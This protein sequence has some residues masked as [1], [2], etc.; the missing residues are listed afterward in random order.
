MH[1]ASLFKKKVK[2][3][4]EVPE[5]CESDCHSESEHEEVEQTF[6]VGDL[7]LVRNTPP[8]EDYRNRPELRKLRKT[9][10]WAL[11]T[12]VGFE[13]EPAEYLPIGYQGGG[14]PIVTLTKS[15]RGDWEKFDEIRLAPEPETVDQKARRM[16][17]AGLKAETRRKKEVHSEPSGVVAPYTEGS[18]IPAK[19]KPVSKGNRVGDVISR[20]MRK[21]STTSSSSSSASASFSSAGSMSRVSSVYSTTTF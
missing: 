1:I 11:A 19:K 8:S 14:R 20:R 7:V 12:V 3:A 9:W 6:R 18:I 16:K 21:A 5:I 2:V 17:K 15:T 10:E 13:D 4:S